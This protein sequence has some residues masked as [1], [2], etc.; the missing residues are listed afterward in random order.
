M[1]PR[2]YIETTIPSYLTAW[3]SSH[4]VLFARQQIIRDWWETQ[5][6]VF[7]LFTSTLVHQEA[8]RGDEEA[9]IKRTHL[10]SELPVLDLS[11]DVYEVAHALI[12]PGM[13]PVAYFDDALHVA[14]AVIH[15]MDYLLTWNLKHIANAALR[16][17]F[18]PK[19][20]S[21]GY[22][23]PTICTPEELML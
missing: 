3:P 15:G 5:R 4:V 1:K 2:V 6:A 14:L 11:E 21:L 9:A 7:D 19:I 10:L 22:E 17:K 20:R 16:N 8:S 12:E 23:V 18:E 13:L